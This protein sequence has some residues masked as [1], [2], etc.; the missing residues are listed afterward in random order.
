[1]AVVE[2]YYKVVVIFSS[3]YFVIIGYNLGKLFFVGIGMIINQYIF[4]MFFIVGFIINMDGIFV[5]VIIENISFQVQGRFLFLNI[6]YLGVKF[7]VCYW[8][9][10]V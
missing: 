2:V 6:V 3:V 7:E 5:K 9:E 1:M 4:Y 8:N 10:V